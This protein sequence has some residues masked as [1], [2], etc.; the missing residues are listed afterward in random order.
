MSERSKASSRSSWRRKALNHRGTLSCRWPA[1]VAF[2]FELVHG[3]G[4][5]GAL[6]QIGLPESHLSVALLTFN[7]GVEFGQLLV[8]GAAF[9]AC[10]AM[11]YWRPFA[12]ARTPALYAVGSIAAYWSIGRIVTV[13]G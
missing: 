9:I 11:S 10:R 2:L 1:L 3:L 8:V 5:A 6:K 7:V 12:M 4:F 13:L